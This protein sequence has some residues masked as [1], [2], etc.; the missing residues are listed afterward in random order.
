MMLLL[1]NRPTNRD[2]REAI[3]RV[4][5][6]EREV[7]AGVEPVSPQQQQFRNRSASRSSYT[8]RKHYGTGHLVAADKAFHKRVMQGMVELG[9]T[10]ITDIIRDLCLE[11][12]VKNPD[13]ISSAVRKLKR[14]VEAI[15]PM[16]AFIQRVADLVIAGQR[17][18]VGT[19]ALSSGVGLSSLLSAS[20]RDEGAGVWSADVL[21]N[22]IAELQS[23]GSEIRERDSAKVIAAFTCFQLWMALTTVTLSLHCTLQRLR[24]SIQL[25]LRKRIGSSPD[26]F[27]GDL[28]LTHADMSD[29]DLLT[30]FRRILRSESQTAKHRAAYAAA[31]AELLA[32]GAGGVLPGIVAHFGKLFD[33]KKLEGMFPR[34][35]V[36]V[37]SMHVS[38]MAT[39]LTLWGL[40][41]ITGVVPVRERDEKLHHCPEGLAR[42]RYVLV[43]VHESAHRML[44]CFID[45]IADVC[46]ADAHVSTNT[47][48]VAI[49]EAVGREDKRVMHRTKRGAPPFACTICAS[50]ALLPWFLCPCRRRR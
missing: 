46:D 42:P 33:V 37:N 1:Q 10:T 19:V 14:A 5:E 30:C 48:L 7:T 41:T 13:S 15:P 31:E 44:K 24:H 32:N 3:R 45:R 25:E 8:D 38:S 22:C 43:R 17:D 11:L 4:R 49:R 29:E 50:S 40:V 16:E 26:V 2:Y 39:S 27:T 36:R 35:N 34:M 18:R 12:G 20:R 21:D 9:T 47:L 6:L 28:S 23:W